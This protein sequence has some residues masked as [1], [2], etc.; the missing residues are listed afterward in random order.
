MNAKLYIDGKFMME[1]APFKFEGP[2]YTIVSHELVNFPVR[3]LSAY[4][5]YS[6]LMTAKVWRVC[7]DD[8]CFTTIFPSK[9]AADMF[10]NQTMFLGGKQ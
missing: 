10:V 2:T 8:Y 1:V 5:E 4:G 7:T 9:T 6:V 3:I